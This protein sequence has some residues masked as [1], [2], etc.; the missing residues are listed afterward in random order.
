[1]LNI[2]KSLTPRLKMIAD[3]VP[4]CTTLCDIGTDHAYVA[5]YLAKKGR[6][7]KI[8]AADIKKGPLN[9]A[10]K[11]IASFEI[12]HKIE[13][14]LSDGFSG[15]GQKEADCAIIAGM[16][17]ETIAE[18][19]ENEKGCK[20]FV[21]QMQTAHKH[22]REYLITH[23]YI[24]KKESI[25]REGNK[26]YAA[27]LA[28]RGDNEILSDIQKEI[29]PRLIENPS[30]LFYDYVRYRLYE[31]DS[32]LK[33]MGS[34]TGEKRSLCESLKSEYEKLLEGESL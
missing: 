1:M 5:I 28:V 8:I 23:G 16:G 26:M 12:G 21:L 10:E 7:K 31:I 17:G 6:A 20:Y 14:R 3:L 24:I 22:L 15:I 25:C 2:E 11:N 29:G 32:I 33:S 9:Q 13:T 4:S 34:T 19:L 18:I 30:P 27:L